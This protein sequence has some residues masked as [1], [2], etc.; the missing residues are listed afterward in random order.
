[1]EGKLAAPAATAKGAAPGKTAEPVRNNA[2]LYHSDQ[3]CSDFEQGA[4][5]PF[6]LPGTLEAT[7]I[8]TP[9]S[10]KRIQELA[11]HHVHRPRVPT[12]VMLMGLRLPLPLHVPFSLHRC[13]AFVQV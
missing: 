12:T 5:M 10:R 1:M 6:S 8:Y 3:Q 11:E 7:A 4:S 13:T 2:S 9:P